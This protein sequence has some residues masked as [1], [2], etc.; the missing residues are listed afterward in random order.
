MDNV[1]FTEVFVDE[2]LAFHEVCF[3]FFLT[4]R[5]VDTCHEN[6]IQSF[7]SYFEPMQ[8]SGGVL[9]AEKDRGV[10][11]VMNESFTFTFVGLYIGPPS[12]LLPSE[13]L[14]LFY[15]YEEYFVEDCP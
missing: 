5:Y 11:C 8:S 13:T 1:V 6:L 10:W 7:L 14:A 2:F 9:N 3:S 15:K 4:I 12:Y